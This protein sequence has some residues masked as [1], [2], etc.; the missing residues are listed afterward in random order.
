[1]MHRGWSNY[2]D[3]LRDDIWKNHPQIHVWTLIFT[4]WIFSITVKTS[5]DILMAAEN[6][7]DIHPMLKVI[8]VEWKYDPLWDP[9]FP[10]PSKLVQRF[11]KAI[12]KE[13]EN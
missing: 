8:P 13:I 1:M 2:V 5:N 9:L 6:W 3:E 11:L 12:Q 7:K 4:V 10:E